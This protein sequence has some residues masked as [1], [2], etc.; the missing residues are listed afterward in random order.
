MSSDL[1]DI[2]VRSS[3]H[4][5]VVE[6]FVDVFSYKVRLDGDERFNLEPDDEQWIEIW[7]TSFGGR[8]WSVA[9][10]QAVCKGQPTNDPYLRN[11]EIMVGRFRDVLNDNS[12]IPFLDFV[13]SPLT[14]TPI[15]HEGVA[16]GMA[17]RF[18]TRTTNED[19]AVPRRVVRSNLVYNVYCPRPNVID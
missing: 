16:L 2:N 12:T 15:L 1:F 8:R 4:K 10:F 19:E 18:Q 7:W 9:S 6:Q 13:T 17:A 5:I 11:F 14:P 3:V